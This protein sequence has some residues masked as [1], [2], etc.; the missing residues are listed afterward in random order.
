MCFCLFLDRAKPWPNFPGIMHNCIGILMSLFLKSTW[1]WVYFHPQDIV[2]SRATLVYLFCFLTFLFYF[3][4]TFFFL[5]LHP[6]LGIWWYPNTSQEM[7]GARNVRYVKLR[8]STF[9]SPRGTHYTFTCFTYQNLKIVTTFAKSMEMTS[10]LDRSYIS[11][12][13]TISE[14]L[15]T[16]PTPW[17]YCMTDNVIFPYC[18]L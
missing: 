1:K 17:R 4:F 18:R 6:Y 7:S 13:E 2:S 16:N 15:P 10:Y 9:L 14:S 8:S 12:R 11:I 3:F 5:F